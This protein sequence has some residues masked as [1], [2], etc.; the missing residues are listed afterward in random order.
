MLAITVR[1]RSVDEPLANSTQPA[2]RCDPLTGLPDRDALMGRLK[3]MLD[4]AAASKQRFA[5]LF[6]DVDG[7]KQ[8]NDRFGHLIG[9]EVLREVAQRL[10]ACVRSGDHLARFGGDEFVVLVD[11]IGSSSGGV[12]AVVNRIRAAFKRS[13]TLP[14]AKVQM[15]VSVG[16]AEPGAVNATAEDLLRAADRAMYE[17]KR[18]DA[19]SLVASSGSNPPTV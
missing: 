16:V 17:A 4:H 1:R 2:L 13:F 3:S 10:A 11:G 6:I 5:V 12:R 7:F 15:S 14:D 19:P 8:V 9:D 18:R